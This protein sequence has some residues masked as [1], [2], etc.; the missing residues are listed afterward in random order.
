MPD[1]N[2]TPQP[3]NAI[4]TNPHDLL[5]DLK[6]AAELFKK[7]LEGNDID[8]L[9]PLVKNY[10][11]YLMAQYEQMGGP[12]EERDKVV[13][14]VSNFIT[15]HPTAIANMQKLLTNPEFIA[16]S[17][18]NLKRMLEI[19]PS[20]SNTAE[21]LY[22]ML[23]EKED[24]STA[25]EVF[26][27]LH[28]LFPENPFHLFKLAFAKLKLN[29]TEA[30]VADFKK[31]LELN[32]GDYVAF[33]NMG[34]CYEELG[35]IE[36]AKQCYQSALA[37]NETYALSVSNLK[38]IYKREK[39]WQA[40]V[41]LYKNQIDKGQKTAG[42]Y[43]EQA[44]ATFELKD[45][46][47]SIQL[48]DKVLEYPD[49]TLLHA[50]YNNKAF[51]F[52]KLKQYAAAKEFYTLSI[53]K[54]A[55]YVQAYYNRA[56]LL[57][58]MG[59]ETGMM[60]DLNKCVE[61]DLLNGAAVYKIC[62]VYNNQRRFKE[63][64]TYLQDLLKR[65]TTP[66][67]ETVYRLAQTQQRLQDFEHSLESYNKAFELKYISPEYLVDKAILFSEMEK[68][69]DA[70]SAFKETIIKYPDY[71]YGY[72]NYAYFML[73]RRRYGEAVEILNNAC[74]AGIKE[75]RKYYELGN[76]YLDSLAY[77][78]A[79]KA[80]DDALKLEPQ[81]VF[82]LH[83]K[84][85][86]YEKLG[87]FQTARK[88]W[89][90]VVDIYADT[91]EG[92]EDPDIAFKAFYCGEILTYSLQSQD[93]DR[94]EKMYLK[95]IASDKNYTPAY[96]SLIRLY[97]QRK[98]QMHDNGS[99]D[100]FHA[101]KNEWHIKM[102]DAFGTGVEI[103][104]K[105]IAR[106]ATKFNLAELGEFYLSMEMYE[107][108]GDQFKK[109]LEK[110][111]Q[112][113]RGFTGLGVAQARMEQYKEAIANFKKAA[114]LDPDDLN[115]QSNLGDAYRKAEM[116]E[117]AESVFQKILKNT[118]F[119]IDAHMG[120]GECYKTFGD[121]SM[122][123]KDT[124]QSEEYFSKAK[125]LFEK[126]LNLSKSDDKVS[127]RINDAEKSAVNYSL[128]Y[129]KVRLFEMKKGLDLLLLQSAEKDFKSIHAEQDE[130]FKAQKAIKKIKE[131]IYSSFSVKKAAPLFIFVMAVLIFGV[132]QYVFY[133]NRYQKK[134]IYSLN[135]KELA[136]YMANHPI[137]SVGPKLSSWG[138][139][140]FSTVEE[141]QDKLGE[142]LPEK[143]LEQ[144]PSSV[145]NTTQIDVR[146]NISELS[147]GFFTF[148]ALVFM[149]V[150][151][152]LKDITRLKLGSIEM[153]KNAVDNLS[154]STSLGV[155]K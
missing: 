32:P 54:K 81:F 10:N 152:F 9:M 15:A 36:E 96:L 52:E 45:Y 140:N 18:S 51:A 132:V 148:G 44:F 62:L 65:Q 39:N 97:Q 135:K 71:E 146:E 147:Y 115:V 87:D 30:A 85:W 93:Y 154:T 60:S 123:E 120:L 128:G 89:N 21:L 88:Q 149:V 13:E 126:A 79:L 75:A 5:K 145:M 2:T 38:E 47:T 53:Q 74:N 19:Y 76:A 1:T 23:M 80:Y 141:F 131:R 77:G 100:T 70:V 3:G 22:A 55:D 72:Y 37:I 102:L 144:L 118:P 11:L 99:D 130:F 91:I 111:A 34:A 4:T 121:K 58:K 73:D 48:Y 16:L 142:V 64:E 94:I 92:G 105:D 83:N 84:A 28:D 50:A 66:D 25:K 151:L 63:L 68:A 137:D 82:A 33:H 143:Y 112:F 24:Y 61:I 41:N 109:S 98:Q 134:D 107:E 113:V 129:T 133:F 67:G 35:K 49:Y 127:K 7:G 108:A 14:D 43:F 153:D 17:T 31:E 155:M 104:K 125:A 20:D 103:L 150:G 46:T 29:E 42:N 27:K 117:Q 106:K 101:I 6:D 86:I 95:A 138:N 90:T 110:D 59:E 56:L 124:N 78:K 116:Y 119:Y 8:Q 114:M 139:D 26:K 40:I 69:D 122:E 136:A 57:E 12:S